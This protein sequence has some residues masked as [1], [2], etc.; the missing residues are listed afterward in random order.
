MRGNA[1]LKFCTFGD[2]I[3]A[4]TG[5]D[6]DGGEETGAGLG[7]VDGWE[8]GANACAVVAGTKDSADAG[9]IFCISFNFCEVTGI[10]GRN[11][12]DC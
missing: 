4:S 5:R 8:T 12:L 1:V 10:E 9:V 3:M 7:R 11:M 2:G 6:A